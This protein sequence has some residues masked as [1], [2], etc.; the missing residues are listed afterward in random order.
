M[1][2]QTI[3]SQMKDAMRA[4]DAMKLDTLRYALS[5][6]KYVQ[7]E[8]QRDLDDDEII[9]VLSKEVK[10]R[11]EAIDLFG[12]S[13]REGLVIEENAKLAVLLQLLPAELPAE[14]IE[15]VVDEV[16]SR[17]GKENMGMVM[18][19]VMAQVKGK[20]DGKMVSDIVRQKLA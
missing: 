2:M 18:K 1:I 11:R 12:K 16:V 5:Q 8:K 19:E 10:K 13:G 20:A 4:K 15:K 3:Q 6:I 7:I 14:D 17:L 9:D